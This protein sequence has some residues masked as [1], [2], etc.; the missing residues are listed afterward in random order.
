MNP[1]SRSVLVVDDDLSYIQTLKLALEDEYAITAATSLKEVEGL[2]SDREF[3]TFVLDYHLGG[4]E[5]GAEI[6]DFLRAKELKQPV[7]VVSGTNTLEMA[8]SFLTRRV[9][10]FI[11]KPVALAELKSLLEEA[12]YESSSPVLASNVSDELGYRVDS[13]TRRVYIGNEQ[14]K[15]TRIEFEILSIFLANRRT[16][17]TREQITA[18]LW[19]DTKVSR[20]TLDTHLINLKR[21]LPI[22]ADKL[23]SVYGTGFCYEA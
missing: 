4:G 16:H 21:K 19:P 22:F 12:M 13:N 2:I 17:V 7:I 14:T 1:S 8:R 10:G 20:H 3:G 11:E 23:V 9:F 18:Q 15:L 6:L 5:N